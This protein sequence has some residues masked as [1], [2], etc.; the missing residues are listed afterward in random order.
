[1]SWEGAEADEPELE[2]HVARLVG[3]SGTVVA[4]TTLDAIGNFTLRVPESH[5]DQ[6]YI[7]ELRLANRV[8]VLEGVRLSS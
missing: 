2:G 6:E 4:E 5:V 3:A 8:V 1:V 7:V